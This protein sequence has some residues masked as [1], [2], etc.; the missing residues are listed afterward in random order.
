[1][2]LVGFHTGNRLLSGTGDP[3]C[4]QKHSPTPFAGRF[5]ISKPGH[6]S[7]T[8]AM[9]SDGEE[10]WPTDCSPSVFEFDSIQ[11]QPLQRARTSGSTQS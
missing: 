9:H 8:L 11:P 1:M 10:T 6:S 5:A 4:W 2:W 3:P 7:R